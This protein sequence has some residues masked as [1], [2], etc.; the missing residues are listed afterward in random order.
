MIWNEWKLGN[1]VQKTTETLTLWRTE[2]GFI[3]VYR[4]TLAIP[5]ELNGQTKGYVFHGSGRLLL[6]TIVETERG[7]IGK[8][9]EKKI[10]EPFLMLGDTSPVQQHLDTADK[11]S[12]EFAAKAEELCSRFFRSRRW[13]SIQ[14]CRR[15]DGSIF[16]FPNK[17]GKFD[18]LVARDSKLVYKALDKIFVS[19]RSKT[20]LKTPN[21]VILSN[22]RKSL[23]IDK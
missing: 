15:E 7:A 14:C 5:L 13:L 12:E 1:V 18:I 3:E 19:N 23:I 16:A 6:D 22:D 4:D 9:V 11:D 2:K 21:E 17:V 8:S 10:D 20:V